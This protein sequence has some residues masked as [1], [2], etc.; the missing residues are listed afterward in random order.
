MQDTTS[1]AS[2]DVASERCRC[3]GNRQVNSPP[4]YA[5]ASH[6]DATRDIAVDT[7]NGQQAT[8]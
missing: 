6:C 2:D 3:Y 1:P 5:S 7:G 4:P 8:V